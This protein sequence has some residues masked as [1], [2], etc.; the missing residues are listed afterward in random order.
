MASGAVDVRPLI[1][2]VV[3]LIDGAAWFERLHNRE[4]G[5][6]KVILAP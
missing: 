5:L 1:S 3:P 2:G 4:P 6:L